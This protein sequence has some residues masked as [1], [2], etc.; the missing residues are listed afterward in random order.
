MRCGCPR[1]GAF[2]VHEEGGQFLGCRCPNCLASC[3]ACMGTDSVLTRAEMA[4]GSSR[5]QALAELAEADA[6]RAWDEDEEEQ[7]WTDGFQSD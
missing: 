7:P 6:A 5:L 1:C 3:D 2:M 4:A